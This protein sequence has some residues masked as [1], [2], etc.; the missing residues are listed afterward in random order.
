[1]VERRQCYGLKKLNVLDDDRL[2]LKI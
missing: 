1:V 2:E